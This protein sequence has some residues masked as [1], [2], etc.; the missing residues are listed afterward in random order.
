MA[1]PRGVLIVNSRGREYFYFQA[2][3]NTPHQGP[4]IPLPNDPHSPEFWTALR[5]A[6]GIKA[7]MRADTVNALI[8]SFAAAWPTLRKQLSPRTQQVYRTYFKIA[9]EAW[10]ELDANGL[11]PAH[12]QAMMDKLAATPGKANSFLGTMQ[13]LNKWARQRGHVRRSFVEDVRTF[14]TKGGHKPWTTAQI[15]AAK[16]KLTGMMR[17][18]FVI[19]LNTG[20]RGVDVVRLG[21]THIDDGGFDVMQ[22]KTGLPVWVPIQRELAAEMATWKKRPGP[23][24]RSVTG[25]NY[26]RT[27]FW[28]DFK[29][30]IAGIPELKGVTLHGLRCT[31]AIRL[32]DAGL[33]VPQISNIMGMTMITIQRYVRFA[34]RKASGKAA[35]IK[36]SDAQAKRTKQARQLQN[37]VK[38]QSPT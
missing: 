21:P 22:Q 4:R 25:K 3:R 38:L 26:T 15:E 28:R 14:P 10:G 9:R 12:V 24:L 35:L 11:E 33:E 18:G 37:T 36:L 8:G 23:F 32:R 7:A 27:T 17:R 19:Y 2:G 1:F 31:A 13:A 30:A 16:T 34:D 5:Q 6:Q 29:H 20:L